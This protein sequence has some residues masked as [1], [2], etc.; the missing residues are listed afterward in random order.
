MKEKSY[1]IWVKPSKGHMGNVYKL[2]F[3]VLCYAALI[4][5]VYVIALHILELHVMIRAI[6][7]L[8]CILIGSVMKPFIDGLA[9]KIFKK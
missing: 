8:A 5:P 9:D 1:F 6:W 2:L 4:V 7:L 3:K